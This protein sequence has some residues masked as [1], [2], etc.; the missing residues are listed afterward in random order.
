MQKSSQ[1]SSGLSSPLLVL[2]L[3]ST[4]ML[5]SCSKLS[6]LDL[7]SG[8]P[9]VAANTQVGKENI[10]AVSSQTTRS[11]A[12]AGDNSTIKQS[13]AQI[14][15]E[16]VDTINVQQTPVWMIVL[17]VLGW[18]LPSPNEIGRIVRSWFTKAQK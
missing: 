14:A 12:K 6:P 18:L 17:L 15:S 9:N 16:K 1:S 11:E 10:Q 3:A 13:T 4:L 8:G 2:L 5:P 7:L